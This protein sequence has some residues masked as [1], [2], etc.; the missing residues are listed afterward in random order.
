MQESQR[1]EDI[2]FLDDSG[3]NPL[4][5]IKTDNNF[6]RNPVFYNNR[7]AP[8]KTSNSLIN[9]LSLNKATNKL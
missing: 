3:H 4:A 8:N 1:S 9:V 7:A 6:Q 2:S 5:P